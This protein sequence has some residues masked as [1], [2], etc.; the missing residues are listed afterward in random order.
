[1]TNEQLALLL[2]RI[3]G[4]LK[5]LANDVEPLITDGERELELV[6]VGEGV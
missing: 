3:A 2:Y 1:M 4:G 6:W 5:S